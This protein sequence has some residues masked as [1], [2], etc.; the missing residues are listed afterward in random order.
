[1]GHNSESNTFGVMPLL[2]LRNFFKN[3]EQMSV[4]IECSALVV[5][6]FFVY[7]KSLEL[8]LFP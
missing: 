6:F 1:M 7:R 3:G 4:N 2:K 5:V 8:L